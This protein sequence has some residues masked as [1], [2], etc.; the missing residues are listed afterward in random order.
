M[1]KFI[2][3]GMGF[4]CPEG[5]EVAMA[6]KFAPKH[7]GGA[8]RVT[9]ILSNGERLLSATTFID[10]VMAHQWFESDAASEL[11]RPGRMDLTDLDL[12]NWEVNI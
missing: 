5:F 9:F 12:A 6:F 4:N 10:C 1:E 11:A 3:D 8:W 7:E 2:V